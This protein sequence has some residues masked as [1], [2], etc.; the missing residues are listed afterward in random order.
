M[1][2]VTINRSS[3]RLQFGQRARESVSRLLERLVAAVR[4]MAASRDRT[5]A[6][7]V[8]SV[9]AAL[10]V[11]F[12]SRRVRRFGWRWAL[13]LSKSNPRRETSAI[14]F[15]QRLL[16]LLERRGLQRNPDLTPLEF[17][18]ALDCNLPWRLRAPTTAFALAG[19]DCLQTNFKRLNEVWHDSKQREISL[20]RQ[21]DFVGRTCV[22]A[23]GGHATPPLQ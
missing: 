8:F 19:N 2:L 6:L 7:I 11:V 5:L 3:A 16:A 17:A 13:T 18:S 12:I 4:D 22:C 15:Y 20:Q 14:E 23:Q 9:V 10:L 1:W 21:I